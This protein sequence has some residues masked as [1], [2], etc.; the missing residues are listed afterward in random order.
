METESDL[1][2]N[3][4]NLINDVRTRQ[5]NQIVWDYVK[6]ENSKECTPDRQRSLRKTTLEREYKHLF[7][8]HNKDHNSKGTTYGS[9]AHNF[10]AELS[11][12]LEFPTNILYFI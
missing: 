6:F 3:W 5:K 2:C 11:N 1:I 9:L 4:V 10:E 12:W 8:W 7:N